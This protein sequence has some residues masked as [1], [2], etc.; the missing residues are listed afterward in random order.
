MS[1]TRVGAL[2]PQNEGEGNKTAAREFNKA[3][4]RFVESGAVAA[5]AR[6]AERALDGPEKQELERAEAIG[7]SRAAGEDPAIYRSPAADEEEIRRRAHELW[8]RAG[9][10]DGEHQAHWLQAEREING[11]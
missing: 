7:K 5:K 11:K 9:C 2:L 8:E 1:D 3:E 10:P 4:R 6:E